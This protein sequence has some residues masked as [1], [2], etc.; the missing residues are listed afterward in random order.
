MGKKTQPTVIHRLAI[1]DCSIV[2]PLAGRVRTSRNSRRDTRAT[3]LHFSWFGGGLSD[4]GSIARLAPS[5][6]VRVRS[7]AHS[8]E[9]ALQRR[10]SVGQTTLLS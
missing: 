5:Q 10:V 9:N 2:E 3:N 8:Y 1:V 4:A 7:R 6:I